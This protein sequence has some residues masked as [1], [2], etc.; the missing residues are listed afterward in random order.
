MR[1]SDVLTQIGKSSRQAAAEIGI[2][3]T[4]LLN[5]LNHGKPPQRRSAAICQQ[6][7]DYFQH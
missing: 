6:I 5:F 1:A 2:S 4:M 7:T 3:K